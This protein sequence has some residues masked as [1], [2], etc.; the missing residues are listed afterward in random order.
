MVTTE[1]TGRR[2]KNCLI[3]QGVPG[4]PPGNGCISAPFTVWLGK[5]STQQVPAGTL[6]GNIAETTHAVSGCTSKQH[7]FLGERGRDLGVKVKN[8]INNISKIMSKMMVLRWF[9]TQVCW[10]KKWEIWNH[11]SMLLK[12]C[13]HT[14]PAKMVTRRP[15]NHHD[16]T[17]FSGH[18]RNVRNVAQIYSFK[19]IGVTTSKN[20]IHFLPTQE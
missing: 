18:P 17:I 13:S 6:E 3:S 5:S 9:Q 8:G 11:G 4:Y 16:E 19:L 10:Q 1:G 14:W 2:V 7:T 20:Y 15:S 12:P